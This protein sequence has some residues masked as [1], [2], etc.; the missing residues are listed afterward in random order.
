M[1]TLALLGLYPIWRIRVSDR[2]DKWRH[3]FTPDRKTALTSLAVVISFGTVTVVLTL[4]VPEVR[5]LIGFDRP[6][7][8]AKKMTPDGKRSDTAILLRL[9]GNVKTIRR[10]NR[11][12]GTALR[13]LT[14][15]ISHNFGDR[16]AGWS[17]LRGAMPHRG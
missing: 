3:R 15:D 4:T 10:D 6:H 12:C 1:N 11:E 16:P 17:S 13:G 9:R 7:P 5:R 2:I 8:F 14:S